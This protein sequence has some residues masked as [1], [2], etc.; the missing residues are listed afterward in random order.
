M[1]LGFAKKNFFSDTALKPRNVDAPHG[2]R[3]SGTDVVAVR[4][5]RVAGT[6]FGLLKPAAVTG[7]SSLLFNTGS[8]YGK[9]M[10]E[11]DGIL[12]AEVD[13][14]SLAFAVRT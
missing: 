11:L 7:H 9:V 5:S 3:I 2:Y 10:S 1:D 14:D 13:S 8:E 12:C 6:C 4:R